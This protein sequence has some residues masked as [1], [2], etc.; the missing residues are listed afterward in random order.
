MSYGVNWGRQDVAGWL[1]LCPDN[2]ALSR[3]TDGESEHWQAGLYSVLLCGLHELYSQCEET[4][5]VVLMQ[6]LNKISHW[7]PKREKSTY[8]LSLSSLQNTRK[9]IFQLCAALMGESG[10]NNMDFIFVGFSICAFGF[11]NLVLT[12]SKKTNFL[13]LF[14][15][16]VSASTDFGV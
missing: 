3:P 10:Y 8:L 13:L 7:L 4:V 9:P 1:R 2:T 12:E 11:A 15:F 5:C 14:F 16:Y 6:T